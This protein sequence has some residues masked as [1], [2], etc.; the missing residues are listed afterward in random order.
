[1]FAN[2]CIYANSSK[3]L[4]GVGVFLVLGIC[5]FKKSTAGPRLSWWKTSVW[6]VRFTMRNWGFVGSEKRISKAPAS[7]NLGIFDENSRG[8]QS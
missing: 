3:R 8:L 6:L 5:S 7:S 1:M 2:I 4:W